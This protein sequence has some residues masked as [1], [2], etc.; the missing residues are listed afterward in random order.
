MKRFKGFLS[1]LLATLLLCSICLPAFAE[2]STPSSGGTLVIPAQP[3]ATPG[4]R[5][6]DA[7]QVLAER[8]ANALLA[9]LNETS[10]RLQ[11]DIVIVTANILGSRT[12]QEFAEDYFDYNGFGFGPRK[13]G[14][15]L[16]VQPQQN[17]SWYVCTRGFGVN[18]L[19]SSYFISLLKNDAFQT[20]LSSGLYKDAFDR[21][22]FLTEAF[23]TEANGG[24]PYSDAHP[25]TGANNE[26]ALGAPVWKWD[27]NGHATAVF[28]GSNGEETVTVTASPEAGT[29][30]SVPGKDGT[31]VYTAVITYDGKLYT[32]TYTAKTAPQLTYGDP[33][34][35]WEDESTARATFI[36]TDGSSKLSVTAFA[37]DGDITSAP[38]KNGT[39]VYTATVTFEGKTYTDSFTKAPAPQLTYGDPSWEWEN[40]SLAHA[41]FVSTDGS[42]KITVT[43]TA[44]EGDI[45]SAPGKDGSTIYTA[46]VTFEGK[47][48]KNTFS[49]A[50]AQTFRDP[51]WKWENTGLARAT[52]I[53]TD[54]S[55]KLSASARASEGSITSVKKDNGDVVYTAKVKF[56]GTEYTDTYTVKAPTY[57]KPTWT[58]NGTESATATFVSKDK[59]VTRT[60][61]ATKAN[62]GISAKT[63]GTCGTDGKTVYTAK[64]TFGGKAYTNKKSVALSHQWKT[65]LTRATVKAAGS[66]TFTCS[67]CGKKVTNPIA[68]IAKI[69]LSKTKYAENGKV[70]NPKVTVTDANG[71]TLKKNKAYTVAYA[72]GR[73]A[74]GVY[75]VTVTFK[76]NYSGKKTLKFRILPAAPKNVTATPGD[77]KVTIKWDAVPGA[78]QYKVYCM[79]EGAKSFFQVATTHNPAAV[80]G[81][82]KNGTTYLFKVK[83]VTNAGGTA[84]NSASCKAVKVTPVAAAP[85]PAAPAA[86]ATP[87]APQTAAAGR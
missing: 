63:S 84:L 24:H 86:P 82:L 69:S 72:D 58:W 50:A 53:S 59:T 60:V 15:L 13:D 3:A 21:F 61:P 83:A 22:V 16:L 41:T 56:N 64:V 7:A 39:T 85:T 48:Y 19:D 26:P 78:E 45:I 34:W 28:T 14:C 18:A 4:V 36:S 62:G 12:M 70:Q 52:F 42:S 66:K 76:G 40:E 31:I 68:K 30:E 77:T 27:D 67:A 43:A 38:G 54:G 8:D 49:V 44:K 11:F 9:L 55:T 71:K 1:V 73:K 57:G 20:A 87:T 2:E 29:V 51:I 25:Y 33:T 6:A 65:S 46:K 74:P 5:L 81:S 80:I 35:Q 37:K 75:T 10:K 47:T 32:D 79:R 17:R 23:L